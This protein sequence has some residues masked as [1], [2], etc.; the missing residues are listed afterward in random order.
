MIDRNSKKGSH[1]PTQNNVAKGPRK[2]R[3]MKSPNRFSKP[4]DR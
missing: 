1:E 4:L 2:I 3:S